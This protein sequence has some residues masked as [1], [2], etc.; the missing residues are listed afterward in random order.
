[1]E[2]FIFSESLGILRFRE[3]DDIAFQNTLRTIHLGK[4]FLT[5]NDYGY[6]WIFWAPIALVTYPF[7]LLSKFFS[8]HWP[9]IIIPRQISLICAVAS[10]VYLR[11]I[12]LLKKAPE[13]VCA[14]A[15]LIFTLFPTFGYFSLRFGTVNAVMLF[16]LLTFYLALKDEPSTFSGRKKIIL[17]LAVAGGIKLSALLIAPVIFATVLINYRITDLK[18]SAK[19]MMQS[20]F[21]FL[22]VL[23]M[24]ANPMLLFTPFKLEIAKEYWLTL[25]HFIAVTKI[26]AD[27]LSPLNHFYVGVFGDLFN[28]LALS[29]LY[30]GIFIY[31]VKNKSD[32]FLK[33]TLLFGLFV[34][35][36]FLMT[37]IHSASGIGSYFTSVSFL[38]VFGVLGLHRSRVHVM[39]LVCVVMLLMCN[40]VYRAYNSYQLGADSWQHFSYYIKSKKSASDLENS[41]L[42]NECL[43][44]ERD[45]SSIKHIFIDFTVK[46][47]ISSLAYPKMCVSVAWGNLSEL[48]K[49]CA[50]PADYLVLDAQSVGFLAESDFEVK[51]SQVDHKVAED[52]KT[53]RRTRQNLLLYGTFDNHKYQLTC[54]TGEIRVYKKTNKNSL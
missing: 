46:S 42:L 21:T 38:L 45:V 28:L 37:S 33:Y 41:K 1:M 3:I 7:Y 19:V 29:L 13:W 2:N 6:G 35:A 40:L 27:S 17:S 20:V 48:G 43:G 26:S 32:A 30:F 52:Y 54:Q 9:L 44:L 5:I 39:L 22:F 34:I 11:K 31:P 4:R 23:M 36:V 24:F 50:I 16:S 49:Y 10:L 47:T 8:I 15:L 53:D 18:V 14:V 12:L 25:S 51:V